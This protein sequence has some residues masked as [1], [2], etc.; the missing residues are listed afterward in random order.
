MKPLL[1]FSIFV[2]S[3]NLFSQPFDRTCV[4]AGFGPTGPFGV[5][6]QATF[7]LPSG[8]GG[9]VSL[10]G[11]EAQA[12][13]LE[14]DFDPWHPMQTLNE[15]ADDYRAWNVRAVRVFPSNTEKIRWGLEAGPS[16]VKGW[17]TTNH[18]SDDT[19]TT[20]GLSLR[21]KAEF[22][23]VRF[24]GLEAGAQANVNSVRQYYGVD[25]MFTLGVLR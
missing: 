19:S 1:I 5:Q 14:S 18:Y 22:P 21:A 9:S 15:P 25:V 3:T 8:W 6:V 13:G 4:Y 12:Q 16:F 11:W 10:H 23:L 24:F 2:L 17:E 7:F 20:V